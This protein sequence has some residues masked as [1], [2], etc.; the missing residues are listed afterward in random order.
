[1]PPAPGTSPTAPKSK[2]CFGTAATVQLA[3]LTPGVGH[4][5]PANCWLAKNAAVYAPVA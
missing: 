3:T 1:M 5:W 4:R 2:L